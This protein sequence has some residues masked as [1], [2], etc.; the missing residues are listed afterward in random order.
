MTLNGIDDKWIV[1]LRKGVF[2]LVILSLLKS[3]SMY[4]YE[5]SKKLKE[6]PILAI[7]EGAIYP[8]LKRISQKGWID[9]YWDDSLDGPRRKYYQITKEGQEIL[10][11]RLEKYKEIYDVLLIFGEEGDKNGEH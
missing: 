5:I 10:V 2:E 8:I 3:H 4:G 7:S 9:S 1:Q 6:V 11:N